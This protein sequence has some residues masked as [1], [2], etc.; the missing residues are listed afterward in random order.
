MK[1]SNSKIL[2]IGTILMILAA[3][4]LDQLTKYLA[5]IYLK[6]KDP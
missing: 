2:Y 3:V 4:A 6:G 5:V 1:Q